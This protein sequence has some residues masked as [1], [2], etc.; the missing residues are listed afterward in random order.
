MRNQLTKIL[1]K[2]FAS[3]IRIDLLLGLEFGATARHIAPDIWDWKI[4]IVL[5]F[6]SDSTERGRIYCEVRGDG[7]VDGIHKYSMSNKG[8]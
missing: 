2:G 3:S 4:L 6:V 7:F 8:A 5:V 1:L